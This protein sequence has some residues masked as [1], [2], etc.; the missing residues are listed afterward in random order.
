MDP[1]VVLTCREADRPVAEKAL[2][3][4]LEDFRRETGTTCQVSLDGQKHL[5]ANC[6]GGVV[7]SSLEGRIRCDNT[8]EARLEQSFEK[9]LPTLRVRLFGP[10]PNRKFFD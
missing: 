10:S 6:A 9:M 4:A 2:G 1:K 3:R 8:L 5:P 7:A